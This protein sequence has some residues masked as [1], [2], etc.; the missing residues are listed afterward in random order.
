MRRGS[1]WPEPMPV[2][3]SGTRL[4]GGCTVR[5]R[6]RGDRDAHP[7][8]AAAKIWACP[9]PRRFAAT[10]SRS[11]S[12]RRPR[13]RRRRSAGPRWRRPS[14]AAAELLVGLDGDL[15]RAL[16]RRRPPPLPARRRRRRAARHRARDAGAAPPPAPAH[17]PSRDRRRAP[18]QLGVRRAQRAARRGGRAGRR[19]PA[20]CST[21]SPPTA[22][23][24]G[25]AS[26]ACARRTPT[27]C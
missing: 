24:T 18:G 22:A 4:D 14:S 1:A 12:C 15:A 3:R 23:G 21:A 11:A 26:T 8:A 27:R 25:C 10:A 7:A 9:S 19:S 6:R 2:A 17:A 13:G 16:R 20:R 5:F